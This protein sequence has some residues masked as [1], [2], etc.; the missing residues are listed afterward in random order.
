MRRVRLNAQEAVFPHGYRRPRR[1][2]FMVLAW[3]LARRSRRLRAFMF[4]LPPSR[5][6]T[7]FVARY[8]WRQVDALNSAPEIEQ[9][10]RSAVTNGAEL[11]MFSL[12][13][14]YGPDGWVAA[15]REWKTSFADA[16]FELE[17]FANRP[18]TGV[19]HLLF[20]AS[21]TAAGG[22]QLNERYSVR[23]EIEDGVTKRARFYG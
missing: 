18:G 2:P 8:Y 13:R 11:D 9:I 5:L 10:I 21:G 4:E 12:G 3:K 7:W 1:D 16:T 22:A 23:Y 20:R 14:F 15:L 6:R 19:V 17:R